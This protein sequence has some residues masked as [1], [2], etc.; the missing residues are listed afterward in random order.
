MLVGWL[1]D[2]GSS[3]SV[4]NWHSTTEQPDWADVVARVSNAWPVR[5]QDWHFEAHFHII[6]CKKNC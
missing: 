4:A 1:V 6:W 3:T 2:T 5:W